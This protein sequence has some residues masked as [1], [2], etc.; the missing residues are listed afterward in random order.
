MHH[1]IVISI[2]SHIVPGNSPLNPGSQ[3]ENVYR[4]TRIG[5]ARHGSSG[6]EE[7]W[8]QGRRML[9]SFWRYA[10]F[11]P[12]ARHIVYHGAENAAL[13]HG[14]GTDRALGAKDFA[15]FDCT[16]SLHGYFSDVTR[17]RSFFV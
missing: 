5:G 6:A 10:I 12:R 16:A 7:R 2:F 9:D 14:S 15:L 1:I 17:V 8:S 3:K 11:L 4:N 13:P